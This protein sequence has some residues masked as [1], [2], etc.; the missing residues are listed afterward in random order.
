MKLLKV[1]SILALLCFG[2]SNLQA[3]MC[4]CSFGKKGDSANLRAE[5]G[6]NVFSVTEMLFNFNSAGSIYQNRIPAGI[7]AKYHLDKFSLRLSA[8][9]L[10]GSYQT[11]R[12]INGSPFYYNHSGENKGW[13]V[14]AGA[15]KSL[16]AGPLRIFFG[17]DLFFQSAF[18]SGISEGYGD[19]TGPF[20]YSYEF[21]STAGGLAPFIGVNWRFHKRFSL[22][23]ECAANLLYYRTSGSIGP[24][25]DESGSTLLIHPLRLLSVS[26]HFGGR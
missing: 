19:L 11:K 4:P 24:Y 23:A 12:E 20:Q 17:S 3:G 13:E 8:D 1:C 14:R 9:I 21:S 16:F 2:T 15:E 6:L 18:N 26:Y 22:S 7:Q 5:F 10:N 25:R